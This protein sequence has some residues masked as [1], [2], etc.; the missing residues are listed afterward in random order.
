MNHNFM[1]F[2]PPVSVILPVYNGERY[3]AEAIE[4]VLSQSYQSFELIVIDDGS[5]DRSREIAQSFPLIKYVFQA[6]RGVAAA[7]NRGIEI[8]RGEFLTFLDADDL[9]LP[10]KLAL[11]MEAFEYDPALEIVTGHVEQFVSSELDLDAA[12]KYS[13]PDK[14]LP[15]YSPIA[16]MVKRSAFEKT[17]LFHEEYQHGEAISWFSYALYKHTHILVLQD[18][19]A[20][21]R[22]H[23]DNISLIKIN[24]KSSVILRIL[25]HSIDRKRDDEKGK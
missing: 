15:G 16:I 10:E 4:S 7:R 13:F 14:P 2:P 12:K 25:K 17:G 24:E 18:V 3:L 9:W 1:D 11:Q 6:N 8:S 5:T 23:G 21:R 20:R 19:V 22:I